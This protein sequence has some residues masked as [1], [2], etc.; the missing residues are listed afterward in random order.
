VIIFTS[1]FINFQIISFKNMNRSFIN[2][3]L[4]KLIH[5]TFITPKFN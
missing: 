5:L 1:G 4:K 3:K 2:Q